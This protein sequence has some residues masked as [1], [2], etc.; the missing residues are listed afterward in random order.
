MMIDLRKGMQKNHLLASDLRRLGGYF[1]RSLDDAVV[2]VPSEG[3]L[4]LNVVELL[5]I[6]LITA[7]DIP[8][9]QP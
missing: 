5:N 3:F 8:I 9:D 7:Q 4:Q 6:I 2:H 1:G